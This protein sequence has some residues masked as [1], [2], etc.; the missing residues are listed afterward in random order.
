MLKPIESEIYKATGLAQDAE[1]PPQTGERGI[2]TLFDTEPPETV[3]RARVDALIR[4]AGI[5]QN[6]QI[7]TK[8]GTGK[9]SQ[10]L[11][12]QNRE[13]LVLYLYFKHI[14]TE[15]TELAEIEDLEA[16]ADTFDRLMD[17]WLAEDTAP[18]TDEAPAE[19]GTVQR[20]V[21]ICG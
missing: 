19:A 6:Y 12:L 16:E 5:Q 15:E 8:P 17:A 10:K 4:R 3:I 20:A 2:P 21:G 14:E 7:L 1:Q 11:T 13:S 18:E 9:Q